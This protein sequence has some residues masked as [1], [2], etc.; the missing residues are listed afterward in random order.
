ML[1]TR[2]AAVDPGGWLQLPEGG[3]ELQHPLVARLVAELTAQSDLGPVVPNCSTFLVA[4]HYTILT[5]AYQAKIEIFWW[6]VLC[7]SGINIS[8]ISSAEIAKL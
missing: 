2:G 5:E 1:P 7:S 8:C 4:Q 6:E 3:V